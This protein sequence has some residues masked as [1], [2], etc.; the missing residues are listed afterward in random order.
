MVLSTVVHFILTTSNYLELASTT[1]MNIFFTNGP[2]KSKWI[3]CHG[4]CGQI[5]GLAWAF[6]RFGNCF[7]QDSHAATFSS[8]S[9]ST[10]GTTNV[11]WQEL[12]CAPLQGDFYVIR[13]GFFTIALW[14][15]HSNSSE[16]KIFFKGNFFSYTIIRLQFAVDLSL[17]PTTSFIV[18]N[19]S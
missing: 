9:V 2:A 19:S 15:Y 17:Q 8:I 6:G 1:V 11:I 14:N 10:F 7:L 4:N 12:S 18:C 3:Q 5:Q 16:K 13:R